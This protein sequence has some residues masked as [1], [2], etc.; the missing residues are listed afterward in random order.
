MSRFNR[1]SAEVIETAERL[2]D[3]Q[4]NLRYAVYAKDITSQDI[5][6]YVKRMN[7]FVTIYQLLRSKSQ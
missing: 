2:R 6:A 3:A 5:D 7:E 4:Q 1:I